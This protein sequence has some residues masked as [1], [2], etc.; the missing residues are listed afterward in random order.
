MELIHLWI[1]PKATQGEI[2][3]DTLD[4]K[5][6]VNKSYE[7]LKWNIIEAATEALRTRKVY[8]VKAG[9]NNTH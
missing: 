1:L 3:N 7:K 5:D 2:E 6:D 8:Q 4:E 9:S